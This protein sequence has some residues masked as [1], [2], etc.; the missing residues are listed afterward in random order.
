M[1]CAHVIKNE[2]KWKWKHPYVSVTRRMKS[3]FNV[4]LTYDHVFSWATI[5]ATCVVAI[6]DCCTISMWVE[7]AMM[8]FI[9]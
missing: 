7:L 3:L 5:I 1:I 2:S 8:T 9:T 6:D 4:R